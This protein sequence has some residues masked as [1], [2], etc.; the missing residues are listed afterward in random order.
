MTVRQADRA[1]AERERDVRAGD[2]DHAAARRVA[3]T[4]EREVAREALAPCGHRGANR[5]DADIRGGERRVDGDR[6][7]AAER[8]CSV[9]RQDVRAQVA[10][11]AVRGDRQAADAVV[12][13]EDRR[14][15]GL[16]GQRK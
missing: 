6:D 2:A 10:D 8:E 11:D 13:A 5:L 14:P 16:R 15:A 7:V 4:V 9:R 12:E 1:T 3:D